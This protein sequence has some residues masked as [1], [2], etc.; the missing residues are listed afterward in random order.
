VALVVWIGGHAVVAGEMSGGELTAFLLYTT[1]VAV[2]LGAL[3]GLWGALQ[4]AA[5]ATGRLFAIVDAVPEI[6]DP[7]DPRPLPPGPADLSFRDVRFRYPTRPDH[8]VLRGI[9]L[10]VAAGE[11]VALVGP[12]GAGKTTITA[13]VP[14]FFDPTAGSVRLAGVDLRALSLV[15]LR[16]ALALVPQDPVLLGETIAEAVA[17]G[18]PGAD[19]AAVEAACREANAHDFIQALPDGYETAVGERGLQL[20]GGQRQRIAIARALLRDPRVLILDEA[21]SHLDSESAALVQAALTR[22]VA[23]RTTLV[24]AHRLSTVRRADRI[25]VVEDGRIVEEGAHGDLVA[26]GG[27]YHRLVSHQLLD[28]AGSPATGR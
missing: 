10:E 26:A 16:G 25:V 18:V 1:I 11:L 14:R 27:L 17:Y 22:L 5:G 2:S 3:A 19:R 28:D 6:R 7:A 12:S 15:E 21:T 4:R 9:D 13:L 23:G 24:V 20:S 8:E